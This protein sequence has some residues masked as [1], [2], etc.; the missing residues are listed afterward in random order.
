[1]N[2]EID[3][4][5]LN[6]EQMKALIGYWAMKFPTR[7]RKSL[8]RLENHME[9]MNYARDMEYNRQLR[10]SGYKEKELEVSATT[11]TTKLLKYLY[12]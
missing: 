8:E 7:F 11:T 3:Y 10:I 1:M 5:K 12:K 6:A 4:T 9:F 2:Q